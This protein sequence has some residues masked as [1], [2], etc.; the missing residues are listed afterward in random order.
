MGHAM[1]GSR[2]IHSEWPAYV[3][4]ALVFCRDGVAT[5]AHMCVV[6]GV[7]LSF[8]Q[9]QLPL[10]VM[11]MEAAAQPLSACMHVPIHHQT[12]PS[13]AVICTII[14]PCMAPLLLQGFRAPP[15]S[16]R[17]SH[18]LPA[19]L[20]AGGTH[21]LLVDSRHREAVCKVVTRPPRVTLVRSHPDVGAHHPALADSEPKPG[22][23]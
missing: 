6:N 19:S 2:R 16:H 7:W 5:A 21:L 20:R 3:W 8:C 23:F 15:P 11:R 4:D 22:P 9:G 18:V 13:N 1:H 17:S 12:I 14:V 10:V